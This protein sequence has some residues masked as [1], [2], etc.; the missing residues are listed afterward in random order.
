MDDTEHDT[1]L[2]HNRGCAE[3][4]TGQGLGGHSSTEASKRDRDAQDADLQAASKRRKLDPV[5]G[6]KREATAGGRVTIE[7]IVQLPSD[8]QL[9]QARLIRLHIHL[10]ALHPPTW[11]I[12]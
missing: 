2:E 9:V 1:L 5:A 12:W 3:T 8:L 10:L 11:E 4:S 6:R 7:K